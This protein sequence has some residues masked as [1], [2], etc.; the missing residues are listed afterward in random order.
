MVDFSRLI[1]LQAL[2]DWSGDMHNLSSSGNLFITKQAD[3]YVLRSVKKRERLIFA[4]NCLCVVIVST[5]IV[6]R[7]WVCYSCMYSS[8]NRLITA[9][10]AG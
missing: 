10:P 1:L 6:V 2:G 5:C 7:S 4:K 3:G 9:L 8:S